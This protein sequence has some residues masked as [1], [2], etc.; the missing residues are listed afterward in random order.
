M[1]TQFGRVELDAHRQALNDLDPIAGGILSRQER[2][3]SAAARRQADEFSVILDLSAIHVSAQLDRLA[4]PHIT[5][6]NF[7]KVG[8]HPD[9]IQWNNAHKWCTRSN[10]LTHLNRS[11]RDDAGD[12][13]G[14][15]RAPQRQCGVADSR[16]RGQY[17]RMSGN[18]GP[19]DLCR[20]LV[21]FLLGGRERSMHLGDPVPRMLEFLARYSTVA[22]QSLATLVILL[23]LPEI[24][25]AIANFRSQLISLCKERANRPYAAGQIGLGVA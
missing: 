1:R 6:L 12:R 25:L 24:D 11:L 4:D 14:D 10:S 3:S 17:L 22:E 8:V 18:G 9:G 20:R 23:R 19:I 13:R 16:Y 5:Q 2:E 15:A 21:Q 7:L